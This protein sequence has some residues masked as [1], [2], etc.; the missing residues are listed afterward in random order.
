MLKCK[1]IC[2]SIIDTDF[3]QKVTKIRDTVKA[4]EKL[5]DELLLK[6]FSFILLDEESIRRAD[7][8]LEVNRLYN[9][10][11]SILEGFNDNDCLSTVDHRLNDIYNKMRQIYEELGL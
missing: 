1:N 11:I 4:I 6:E 7:R 5:Y 8:I 9:D 2:K 10:L 3:F